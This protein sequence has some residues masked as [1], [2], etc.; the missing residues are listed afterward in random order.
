MLTLTLQAFVGNLL[1]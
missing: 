1:Q